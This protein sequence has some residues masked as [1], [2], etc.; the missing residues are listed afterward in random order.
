MI[1]NAWRSLRPD[2]KFEFGWLQSRKSTAF[3]ENRASVYSV[4]ARAPGRAFCLRNER[5]VEWWRRGAL[6]ALYVC[7]AI[8]H[9]GTRSS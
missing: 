1:P 6:A 4:S 8:S 7:S 9:S 2:H 3:S 5:I